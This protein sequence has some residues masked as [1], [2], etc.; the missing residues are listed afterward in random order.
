MD[1]CQVREIYVAK[2]DWL[3]QEYLLIVGR[4]LLDGRSSTEIAEVLNEAFSLNS[5]SDSFVTR[6]ASCAALNRKSTWDALEQ[7]FTA[8][9]IETMRR[10]RAEK[11]VKGGNPPPPTRDNMIIFGD[12]PR[13]F[14]EY[15]PPGPT[16]LPPEEPGSATVVTLHEHSCKWPIGNPGTDDFTF[17]G[18]YAKKPPYCEEH[19]QVA[20]QKPDSSTKK[21]KPKAVIDDLAVFSRYN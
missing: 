21:K 9:Q 1:V 3:S 18:R 5:E 2:S 11:H 19:R 15:T 12:N 10:L 16:D 4:E 6:S 20:F 13:P 7:H 8:D 17:C 14:G